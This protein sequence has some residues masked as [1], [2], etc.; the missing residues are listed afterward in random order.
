[1]N[2][3]SKA[4]QAESASATTTPHPQ[5]LIFMCQNAPIGEEPRL[6]LK[7]IDTVNLRERNG[8]VQHSRLNWVFL[9]RLNPAI[10]SERSGAPDV[11]FRA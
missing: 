2:K 9:L 6:A 1:M 8:L 11:L 7:I 5:F 3:L 10:L 4:P